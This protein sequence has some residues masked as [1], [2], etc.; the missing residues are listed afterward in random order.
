MWNSERCIGK[1]QND[2]P[3]GWIKLKSIV[4]ADDALYV[5]ASTIVGVGHTV[6]VDNISGRVVTAVWTKYAEDDPWL[7][8]DSIDEVIE[9]IEKA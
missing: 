7:V 6:N 4:N 9:K 8:Y 2:A 3:K 1:E 5:K